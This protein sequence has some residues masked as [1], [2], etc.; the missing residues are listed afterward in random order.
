MENTSSLPVWIYKRDGRLAPFE[1]D[2][3]SQS[4][5]AAG[6]TL[7]Q[8]DAFTA[9]ELTDS[10]LHFLC[11]ELNGAVPNTAQVAELTFKVV[12]EL[13]QT[14]LAQA[15]ADFFHRVDYGQRSEEK[16]KAIQAAKKAAGRPGWPE[17]PVPATLAAVDPHALVQSVA[18][19]GLEDYSL[20]EIFTRDI[21]AAHKTGLITLMGLA[22]PFQ[23]QGGI[24]TR[25]LPGQ[26]AFALE[27][28]RA[29]IGQFIAL[30][31]PEF[32]E[33]RSRTE[34]AGADWVRE[35]L[36]GVRATGLQAVVNL[37]A[38]TPPSWARSLAAGPL[39]DPS[40]AA[41]CTESWPSRADELLGLLCSPVNRGVQVH[42]HLSEAD[43]HSK[44]ESRFAR[45]ARYLL[46]G[47]PI[48]IVF[49]RANRP[50]SLG[51]GLDRRHSGLL[52]SV[53]LHL[54]SLSRQLGEK[55]TPELFLQKL[56]SL[57][58]LAITAAVQKRRFLSRYQRRRTSFLVD[59]ARLA[60]IPIGLESVSKIYTG[61]GILP[62]STGADF[63][64]RIIG[65]LSEILR[66]E[67]PRYNLDAVLDS[68]SIAEAWPIMS[69][70]SPFDLDSS[71]R[72]W[73]ETEND[74]SDIPGAKRK[75]SGLP[76]NLD[77][78]AGLTIWNE[79]ISPR[80][81][82][83]VAGLIHAAAGTGTAWIQFPPDTSPSEEELLS[84]LRYAWRES[85][86]SRLRLVIPHGD[87][88]QLTASWETTEGK[89]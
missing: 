68:P 9:H 89:T 80:D 11:A 37:N 39:F 31:G 6:E 17:L 82:L 26:Y 63:A 87:G 35:L 4:L 74:L 66:G 28:S 58:R 38:A 47:A 7:G 56:G 50:I 54:P 88:R 14:A 20:R 83:W 67:G 16:P 33:H 78:I 85:Q 25:T 71:C 48:T 57:A 24:L 62:G 1:A 72:S 45:L 41:S 34:S 21:A 27:E 23:M 61:Q 15:Y 73:T 3:I 13:G 29:S 79:A 30:D 55:S 2:K 52:T 77:K 43:W 59:R 22:T 76:A 69:Q 32:D 75:Q 64:L 42:W 12:R 19:I 53:G 81:Q 65:S 84:L 40:P 60:V 70:A 5:F 46:H 36:F 86:P 10:V 49:D 8:P 44:N 18:A 51:E